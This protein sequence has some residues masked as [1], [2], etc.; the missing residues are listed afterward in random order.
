MKRFKHVIEDFTICFYG[1]LHRLSKKLLFNRMVVPI[2]FN[3]FS[4]SIKQRWN[5]GLTLLWFLWSSSNILV[6]YL[7]NKRHKFWAMEIFCDFKQKSINE[8]KN[9]NRKR[10]KKSY[11]NFLIPKTQTGYN[12]F[13]NQWKNH[14]TMPW[15]LNDL[16]ESADA[17]TINISVVKY[18]IER[19]DLWYKAKDEVYWDLWLIQSHS[20]YHHRC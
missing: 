12:L 18:N 20:L 4:S 2:P 5:L 19:G 6:T 10:E 3:V 8:W 13:Y 17:E 14:V 7:H 16:R 11:S 15:T 9:I 1:K